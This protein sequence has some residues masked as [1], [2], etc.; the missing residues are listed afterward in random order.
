MR[1]ASGKQIG[2]QMWVHGFYG[3]WATCSYQATVN[4]ATNPQ[5]VYQYIVT[6]KRNNDR[7]IDAFNILLCLLSVIF[8]LFDQLHTKTFQFLFSLASLIILTGIVLN[9][10]AARKQQK[11]VRYRYLLLLAGICWIGMPFLRW[12][13]L[14]FFLLSFLEYQAKYPLEIG[15]TNDAIVINTLFKRKFTWQAFNNIILRDGMLTLDFKNNHIIQ[16]E[17]IDDD[18]PD[19]DEDEFNEFCRLHLHS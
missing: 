13:S 14:L 19:A 11:M 2:M 5:M 3:G 1:S 12:F 4:R 18:E 9:I 7:Y 16:K 6:L 8:F 17:T 10:Y 15:F